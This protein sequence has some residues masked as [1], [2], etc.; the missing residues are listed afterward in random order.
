MEKPSGYKKEVEDVKKKVE[1]SG[2]EKKRRN[3]AVFTC[4]EPEELSPRAAK[5]NSPFGAPPN[6]YGTPANRDEQRRSTATYDNVEAAKKNKP[7]ESKIDKAIKDKIVWNGFRGGVNWTTGFP[8]AWWTSV[9]QGMGWK[10]SHGFE[11]C[12]VPNYVQGSHVLLE[13]GHRDGFYA[14]MNGLDP[15]QVCDGEEHWEVY[16]LDDVIARNEDVTNLEPQC[17]SCNRDKKQ[18]RKDQQSGG[19]Q[20]QAIGKCTGED[21]ELDKIDDLYPPVVLPSVEEIK[22]DAS[23]AAKPNPEEEEF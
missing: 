7:V 3:S 8:E 22:V 13:I 9:D 23:L 19:F 21:C 20:P 16:L 1:A 5:A 10:C 2:F 6:P 18:K 12:Q 17:T 11:N 14:A 4:A 15:V